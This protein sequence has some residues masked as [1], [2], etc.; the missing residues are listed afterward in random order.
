MPI[1][2]VRRRRMVVPPP[3]PRRPQPTSPPRSL[4]G[5]SRPLLLA[6]LPLGCVA[7]G[8]TTERWSQGIMLLAL[9]GILLA[10]P[11]RTNLGRGLN[12]ILATLLLLSLTAFLPAHWFFAPTW[13]T[14]ITDDFGVTLPA[15]LSPQPFLTAES[16]LV[17][18]AGLSWLYRM[19]TVRW[20]DAERLR[21]GALFGGGAV[22]LAAVSVAC[23]RA[24]ITVPI[25]PSERHFGPFPNR[26]QTANFFALA[27]LPVLA[28]ARAAWRTNRKPAALAWLVG[29]LVVALAVFH[30]FSR[31]GIALLA[32]TTAVY[33]ILETLHRTRHQPAAGGVARWRR[34]AMVVSLALVVGTGSLLFGG[35]TVARLRMTGAEA[36][37]NAMSN[38][39]RLSIYKDALDMIARSP[40]CGTGLNTFNEIFPA[41]RRQSANPLRVLHPESDWLWLGAEL[42]WPG[43]LAALVGTL[44]IVR[45]LRPPR[46]GHD[47]PLRLAAALGVAGF[48][49]HSLVDVSAHR[50]GSAFAAL[51]LLGLALPGKPP[52]R[53]EDE[54]ALPLPEPRW[55][56][57]VFRG[58]GVVFLGVGACWTFGARAGWLLPGEPGIARLE[59]T[60]LY[61]A[62]ASDDEAAYRSLSRVLAWSPLDWRA[63]YMRG[64]VGVYGRRNLD[65]TLADFR[66]ARYLENVSAALPANEARLWAAAGQ[67]APA[68]SALLEACRRDPAAAALLI[69]PV[70]ALVGRDPDFL[71]RLTPAARRDPALTVA[72][73]EALVAP[74]TAN[75]IADIT[76]ADPDL[77][78]L[79]D[80]QKTRV[81]ES[82]AARGDPRALVAAMTGHPAWQKLGWRW[83]ANAAARDGT[84][85]ATRQACEIAAR[86][87]PTPTVPWPKVSPL[88]LADL[89]RDVPGE[90]LEPAAALMLYRAQKDADDKPG[91]LQA[92]QRITA[93]PACPIY[94]HYLEATAAGDANRWPVAWAAWDRYLQATRADE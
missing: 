21:A 72:L 74:A 59:A 40:W 50:V 28:C 78:R 32:V 22:A 7:L 66:R 64:A 26:N 9:G 31:A 27:A 62:Q 51:F 5:W 52:T 36:E 14:A 18:A 43:G 91:A 34:L 83:W 1:R 4:T 54:T 81:F 44:L 88:P 11:P 2:T 33:L 89:Q 63:Y 76:D 85:E 46:R 60:A 38:A 68:V 84:P 71:D 73:A 80:H 17:F 19:A 92:L 82:W 69:P 70:D 65:G 42:G 30:S 41:Y 47:R 61:Q 8:G 15:T 49:A 13:R 12:F 56:G 16:L 3:P 39:L 93:Q 35:D 55:P 57:W 79:S 45:R 24:G 20:T 75:F 23:Y 10:S 29:W 86:F 94:F 6:L 77:Q 53:P 67:T 25:W 48:L 58:A 87:A 90:S 37:G